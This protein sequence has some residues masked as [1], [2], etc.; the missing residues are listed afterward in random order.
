MAQ[1]G[2]SWELRIALGVM[3]PSPKNSCQALKAL[4]IAPHAFGMFPTSSKAPK[5][6]KQGEHIS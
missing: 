3:H 6:S 1:I 2:T 4:E 5:T